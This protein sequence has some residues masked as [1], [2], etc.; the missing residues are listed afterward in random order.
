MEQAAYMR[1]VG[2]LMEE[3][4]CKMEEIFTVFWVSHR[5]TPDS[6]AY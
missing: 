1:V 2:C 6:T 3:G 4:R 5:I